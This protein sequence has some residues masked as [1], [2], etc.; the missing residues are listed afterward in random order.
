MR[1]AEILSLDFYDAVISNNSNAVRKF[2]S[3]ERKLPTTTITGM[4]M[5]AV[6]NK[7][8]E[9]IKA[10]LEYNNYSSDKI[11]DKHLNVILCLAAKE[12]ILKDIVITY[13]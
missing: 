5:I 6:E 2:L 10:I 3:E 8:V 7:L 1:N 9:S 13:H 12:N 11:T 4:L